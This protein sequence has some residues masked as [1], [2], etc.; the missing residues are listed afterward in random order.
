MQLNTRVTRRGL[1]AAVITGAA[2][3]TPAIA[4]AAPGRPAAPAAAAPPHC[5]TTALTAWLGIPGNGYAGGSGYQ[6]ELS[7]ISNQAC[8]LYGYPGVSALGDGGVQL[9]SAATRDSSHPDQLITL[10]P[11]ATAHVE[12]L[13][14]EAGNYS[15]SAC[16]PADAVEL[17]VYPPNDYTAIEIP[18]SFQACAKTGPAFLHVT[19]TLNGAGIPGFSS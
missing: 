5:L 14:T 6:L 18:F 4:L 13:I 10:G 12:L 7:N 11:G 2:L 16:H 3:L 19:T 17:R 15:P 8:T 1:A 9:G